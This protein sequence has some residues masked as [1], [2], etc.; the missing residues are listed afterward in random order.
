TAN[1]QRQ[2]TKVRTKSTSNDVNPPPQRALSHMMPCAR[3]RSSL[4]N[5]IVNALVRFGKHPASPAPKR[6]RKMTSET[7][8]K[9]HP[10][11]AVN[12]DHITT[13]RMRT[14]RG[15]M[16]SPSQPPGISKSA[17]A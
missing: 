2:D 1:D 12:A 16:M 15:P 7:I 17:Y 9:A 4:G 14:F 5:Q 6:N 8:L 13:T 10:V 3:T 11:A